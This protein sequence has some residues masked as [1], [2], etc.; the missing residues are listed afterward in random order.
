MLFIASDTTR[1][2][3]TISGP[4][5]KEFLQGLISNDIARLTPEQPLYAALLNPQGKY[6]FDFLLIERGD[7]ILVDVD[8]A[9]SDALMKRLSMYKLRRDVTLQPS[10]HKVTVIWGEGDVP[11]MAIADPRNEALGWRSYEHLDSNAS[12]ADYD[13]H[14]IKLGIPMSGKELVENQ[15]YILECGFETLNGVDFKKGC[16]VGQEVT[17]RM[18]HKTELRKGLVRVLLDGDVET[19]TQIYANEKPVG[20]VHS[21]A[22]TYAIAYLKFGKVAEAKLTAGN[23]VLTVLE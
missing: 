21:V 8:L 7:Q 11:A 12:L 4:E 6:L 16:Y 23:A 5:R 13:A 2:V 17:A 19:G 15:S 14:R 22:G 9:Q 10:D 3:F 18:K 20:T 1:G